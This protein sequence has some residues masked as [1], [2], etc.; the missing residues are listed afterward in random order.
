MIT[1]MSRTLIL[2]DIHHKIERAQSIIDLEHADRIVHLGDHQDNFGDDAAYAAKTATWTKQR[3]DAGDE[4]IIGN[5]DIPYY[6]PHRL[7]TWGCGFTRDKKLEVDKHIQRKQLE[8]FRLWVW[9][10]GWLCSHAGFAKC[11]AGL[12]EG[13][14]EAEHTLRLATLLR[15]CSEPEIYS[16]GRERGGKQQFGGI[17][18]QDWDALQPLSGL[19]QL[20]GH[21]QGRSVRSKHTHD[22]QN[23]CIDTGLR[24][25]AIIEDG[26]LEIR[27]I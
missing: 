24:H 23:Y 16:V 26:K 15:G 17:L 12:Y 18:W 21:T 13:F 9:V 5:H 27:E 11:Y 4:I 19:K 6:F 1:A 3:L 7:H 2:P 25:Y 20:V 14:T 22:S 10:D 8:Q